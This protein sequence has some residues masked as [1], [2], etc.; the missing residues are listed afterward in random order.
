[1]MD[2]RL[3]QIMS[4][5]NTAL[6]PWGLTVASPNI[7][8][9]VWHLYRYDPDTGYC[10]PILRQRGPGAAE[11]MR[12]A[13]LFQGFEPETPAADILRWALATGILDD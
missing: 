6:E 11:P 10:V 2:D 5:T 7:A 1:M 9:P 3:K 12:I 8:P 4:D 13:D